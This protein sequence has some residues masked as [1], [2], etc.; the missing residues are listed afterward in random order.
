MTSE[1][2]YGRTR[3][4]RR[5]PTRTIILKRPEFVAVAATSV[6]RVLS[7]FARLEID[8]GCTVNGNRGVGNQRRENQT[9]DHRKGD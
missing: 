5:T 1:I 4:Q 3:E 2:P 6:H 9:L 8:H 7:P